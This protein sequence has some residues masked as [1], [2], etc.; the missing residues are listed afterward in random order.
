[1]AELN[2]AIAEDNPLMLELL[3]SILEEEDGFHVVGKADNG[4]DAYQ[5][6]MDKKPD[7]VLLDVIMPKLDG[8]TVLEKVRAANI[9]KDMP[10]VIMVTAAGNETVA[11]AAFRNGASYYILKPFDREVLLDKIR[12]V[13]QERLRMKMPS[14]VREKP[15][16]TYMN[17]GDY[18]RRNLEDDVTQLLH[19]I[20]IPAHIKGYQYLRDAIIISV[21][22]Q[23]MMSSRD[24]GS[25]SGHCQDAT[26]TTASRVERAIRHAIEVAWSRGQLETI[27]ESF[28]L[29][30]QQRKRKTNQL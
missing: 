11:S 9:G 19:E 4:E 28:R 5:M 10:A 25:V 29:Y 6:I 16:D 1:M 15:A 26:G 30:S 17:K 12:L 20:G 27:D 7:I 8:I 22:D 21:E 13:A 24:E 23:E 18:I 14:V 2:I 3:G